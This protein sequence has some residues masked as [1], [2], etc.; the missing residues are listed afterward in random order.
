M[1]TFVD[2]LNADN[3]PPSPPPICTTIQSYALVGD[4]VHKTLHHINSTAECCSACNAFRHA[5]NTSWF[6]R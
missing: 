3:V 6:K 5:I 1:L 4:D 2:W